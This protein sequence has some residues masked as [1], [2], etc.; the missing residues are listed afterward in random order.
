MED[1][2]SAAEAA[3]ELGISRQSAYRLVKRGRLQFRY[4]GAL[5][6]IRRTSVKLLKSDPD[7]Q[8]RSRKKPESGVGR[9]SGVKI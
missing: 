5:M 9:K 2:M 6:M 1:W 4:F 7:Y 8:R 3:R